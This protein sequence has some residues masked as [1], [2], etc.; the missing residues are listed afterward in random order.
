MLVKEQST[1]VKLARMHENQGLQNKTGN[2]GISV[3]KGIQNKMQ[4]ML[5]RL[6]LLSIVDDDFVQLCFQIRI[7]SKIFHFFVGFFLTKLNFHYAK[8]LNHPLFL[9]ISKETDIFKKWS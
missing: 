1:E 2:D 9:Y 5:S 8:V 6:R 4:N 3:I 7:S